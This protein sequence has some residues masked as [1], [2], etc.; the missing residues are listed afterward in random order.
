MMM[1]WCWLLWYRQTTNPIIT[2]SNGIFSLTI[3]QHHYMLVESM[4]GLTYESHHQPT[5]QSNCIKSTELKRSV[6]LCYEPSNPN[7]RPKRVRC[8]HED[9]DTS[10]SMESVG[11]K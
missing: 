9:I 10:V 11:T 4:N 2:N 6:Y 5:T 1:G 8:I 3:H 7:I